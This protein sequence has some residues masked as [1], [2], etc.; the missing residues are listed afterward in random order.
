MNFLEERIIKDGIVKEGNVLKVDSFLNHQ[1]DI[2]LFEQMG[3]EFKRRF[4]DKTI[5]KILT[6]EAS[7]IGIACVVAKYFNVPVVFAK[8]SKSINIE[9]EMYIAEVES[10]TH[11]C[12]NQVIVSKKFLNSDDKVL[13]IDDF[14]ANGCA[15]QGLIS[16]VNEAGG[17]VEGIGIAIEK[18][19]Q[20][21]GR[22]IRNLGYQLESLAIVESMDAA[23]GTIQFREQ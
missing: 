15:L 9:G 6:I 5:N 22:I 14:L 23:N 18:G 10:F 11:K 16:I 3:E 19:F 21:G 4:A 2:S 7:G 8:K 12:R 17:T 20:S 1:M 13:I